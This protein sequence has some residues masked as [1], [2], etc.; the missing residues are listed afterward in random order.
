MQK[1][2]EATKAIK[3]KDYIQ[4]ETLKTQSAIRFS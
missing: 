2:P 4:N 1:R 3:D